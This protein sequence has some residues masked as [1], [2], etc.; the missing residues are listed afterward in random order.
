[1]AGSFTEL[2]VWQEAHHL[3]LEVYRLTKKFPRE[4]IYGLTDQLRRASVSVVSNIA[5]S[6][7]RHH[8]KDV[9]RFLIDARGSLFEVQAQVLIS[10]DLGYLSVKEVES[11]FENYSTLSKKIN[12]LITYKRNVK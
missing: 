2:R 1:M 12:S 9:I 7:G 3:A 8:I 6:H 10:R 11:V 5:E 4:E